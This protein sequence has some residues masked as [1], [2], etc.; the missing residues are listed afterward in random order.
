MELVVVTGSTRGIGL[1]LATELL[2]RN[3]GVIINGRSQEAVDKT[4][5]ML[6]GKFPDAK[7][8]GFPCDVSKFEE[9]QGLWDY[10]KQNFKKV[11]IWINN[12][13]LMNQ[14]EHTWDLDPQDLKNIVDVNL[15]GSM[16]CCK[17]AIQGMIKQGGGHIYNFEGFG[18]NGRQFH[19][20]MTPYGS[21]KSAIRYLTRSLAKEAK[22]T[23]VKIGA[24]APGIVV[25]DLLKDPYRNK[26]E[27]WKKAKKIFNILGDSVDT[28]APYI[29]DQVLV[30][31][32]SGKNI[33]WLTFGKV[34]G[35]F[36]KAT[37]KKRDLFAN[38]QLNN[39]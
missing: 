9:V 37:V 24:I 27:E 3:R 19:P 16:Y 7:I 8:G 15:L 14:H 36:M 10:A 1:G 17:V 22:D 33:E 18:S 39:A 5:A 26:P 25:T 13:G 32:D 31:R 20:Y 4:V 30:P 21:S 28:V 23:G 34:L 35:R 6:K 11:D 12:A 2:K 38:D 29:A